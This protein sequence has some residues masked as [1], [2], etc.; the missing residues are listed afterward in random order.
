MI[1]RAAKNTKPSSNF[2]KGDAKKDHPF[3]KKIINV[4]FIF[5]RITCHTLHHFTSLYKSLLLM[6]NLGKEYERKRMQGKYQ[7]TR[8][9]AY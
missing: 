7:T 3:F 2:K 8:E 5:F 4:L 9:V 6:G 1:A